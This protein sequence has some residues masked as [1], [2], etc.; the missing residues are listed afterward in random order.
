MDLHGAAASI[1]RALELCASDRSIFIAA[2][3]LA[4]SLQRKE[5]SCGV[6]APRGRVDPLSFIAH[7]N[8]ALRCL[9]SGLFD[10]AEARSIWPSNSTRALGCCMRCSARCASSRA[11]EKR[12]PRFS[13]KGSRHCACRDRAGPARIGRHAESEATLQKLIEKCADNG[14]LQIAEAFAYLGDADRAFEWLE[15]AYQQR[16]TGLP[17]MQSWP[18]LRN[19]HDDPRWQ[20]FLRRWDS[21]GG[22]DLR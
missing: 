14:A 13:R 8:L 17:Q 12:W 20:P 15:R 9:N 4:D 18:L 16:D 1:A 19:L 21:A 10:E 7:G 2:S 11:A 22:I 3:V 5:E 6:G